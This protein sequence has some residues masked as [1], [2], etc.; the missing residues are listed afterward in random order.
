M[1]IQESGRYLGSKNSMLMIPKTNFF[2]FCFHIVFVP[3][4]LPSFPHPLR[5]ESRM[6]YLYEVD[7]RLASTL[8][9]E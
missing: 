1:S 4:E 3:S 5:I 2:F 9:M 7:H 6:M 8:E